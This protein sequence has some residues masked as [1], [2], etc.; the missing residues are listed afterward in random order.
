MQVVDVAALFNLA[1]YE[2]T[3]FQKIE[4][5]YWPDHPNYDEMRKKYPWYLVSTEEGQIRIGW[6]KRVILIDWSKTNRRGSVTD[7]DVTKSDHMVHAWNLPKALEYLTAIRRLPVVENPT[8]DVECYQYSGVAKVKEGI[9]LLALNSDENAR[10][11][12]MLTWVDLLPE[13]DEI[14]LTVTRNRTFRGLEG[15]AFHINYY[16]IDV[17][18]ESK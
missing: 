15:M 14:T 2:P 4:N 9:K 11:E 6:R 13:T 18:F 16:G 10:L 12:K 17:R 7:D 1:G 5:E 3:E 8:V